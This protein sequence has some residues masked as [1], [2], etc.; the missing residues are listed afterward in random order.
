M[1]LEGSYVSS[2]SMFVRE[3]GLGDTH[4]SIECDFVI[5]GVKGKPPVRPCPE[6][7]DYCSS[8]TMPA[9]IKAAVIAFLLLPWAVLNR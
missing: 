9:L 2:I 8:A 4:C 7:P 6:C 3:I 1:D 5:S